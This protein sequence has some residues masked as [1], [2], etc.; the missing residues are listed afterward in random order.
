VSDYGRWLFG[1]AGGL[2]QFGLAM[3]AFWALLGTLFYRRPRFRMAAG[4]KR[5]EAPSWWLKLTG[6]DRE[7]AALQERRVL[8]AGCGLSWDPSVYLAARRSAMAGSFAAAASAAAVS[9]AGWLSA[10]AMWKIGLA[11][12]LL[13]VSAACDRMA[14]AALRGYRTDRI[15]KEI[16]TVSRQLLYYTGS[17]LHLHGKL[18]RCFPHARLI[19][20]DYQL[21][22]NE[23][24]HDADG[25]LQRFKQRLGTDEAAAFAETVRSLRLNESEEVYGMLRAVVQDF[26]M[27]IELAKA[28]RKETASYLLFVLAGIPILYTFQIFLYPWV[29]EAQ[30]LFDQLNT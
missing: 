23:W 15:R 10:Y 4:W 5:R 27:K 12:C 25:A 14:L 30:R 11:A 8:L 22:L 26:K 2:V 18:M 28:G 1:L 20:N 19:R 24:Y 29:Q 17:R 6:T 9:Q 21:L 7:S 13:F 3:A 16:V